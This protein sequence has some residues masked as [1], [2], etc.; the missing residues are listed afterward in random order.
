MDRLFPPL[1]YRLTIHSRSSLNTSWFS[2][3]SHLLSQ[4]K[5]PS[6]CTSTAPATRHPPLLVPEPCIMCLR[7]LPFP[8]TVH[9]PPLPPLVCTQVPIR[10]WGVWRRDPL[11]TVKFT[12]L[13]YD[14]GWL[15]SYIGE[16]VLIPQAF[17]PWDR[18]TKWK[19]IVVRVDI[20]TFAE[21]KDS[22]VTPHG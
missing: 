2:P 1:S 20:H 18:R 19:M 16:L 4:S 6:T 21:N 15:V 17:S 12:Q 10:P 11:L 5:A 3:D 13:V 22:M 9:S 14:Q 7:L 8:M